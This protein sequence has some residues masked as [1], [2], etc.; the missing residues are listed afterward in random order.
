MGPIHD[1]IA[2]ISQTCQIL[3]F[4]KCITIIKA[5]I[6]V[7]V[8]LSVT[9]QLWVGTGSSTQDTGRHHLEKMVYLRNGLAKVYEI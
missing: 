8:V 4:P 5:I 9:S 1:C 7:K 2:Y 3:S 6:P